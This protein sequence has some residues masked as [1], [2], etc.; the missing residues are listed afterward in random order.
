MKHLNQIISIK[1]LSLGR[2]VDQLIRESICIRDVRIPSP[3]LFQYNSERTYDNRHTENGLFKYFIN[4]TVISTAN[5]LFI[6]DVW[7]SSYWMFSRDE[8]AKNGCYV[9]FIWAYK[10][11]IYPNIPDEF[12]KSLNIR[13]HEIGEKTFEWNPC[14]VIGFDNLNVMLSANISME[15]SIA[16]A[17]M[18]DFFKAVINIKSIHQ[19]KYAFMISSDADE[20]IIDT[21]LRFNDPDGRIIGDNG[22]SYNIWY[23][24]NEYGEGAVFYFHET[25]FND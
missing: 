14:I 22:K 18:V 10:D 1:N 24:N 5:D 21:F 7:D 17:M 25:C 8:A 3:E 11:T 4:D 6:R 19:N 2:R 16:R 15:T 23:D 9:P 12:E 20:P 13:I